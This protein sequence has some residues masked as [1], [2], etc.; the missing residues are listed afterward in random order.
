MKSHKDDG[1]QNRQKLWASA[2]LF[3]VF[4]A[5]AAGG[6][7]ANQAWGSRGSRCEGGADRA[8]SYADRLQREL[9][10]TPAQYDTVNQILDHHQPEMHAL[11]REVRPRI[12]SMRAEIRSQIT[13]VLTSDQLAKY[14]QYLARI[15]IKRAAREKADGRHAR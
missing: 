7:A 8:D 4:A 3:A 1:M 14:Q 13:D 6:G 11:W 15:E 12:D 2:L 10:L 9:A 5:G